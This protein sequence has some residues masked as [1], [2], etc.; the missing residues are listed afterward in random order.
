MHCNQGVKHRANPDVPWVRADCEIA[1]GRRMRR[2]IHSPPTRMAEIGVQS[3]TAGVKSDPRKKPRKF[4]AVAEFL[5]DKP[6]AV[7]ADIE[8]C[9]ISTAK[10][11]LRGGEISAELLLAVNHELLKPQD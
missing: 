4:K 8:H 9:S 3:C 1:W 7:I 6:A 5:W 2:V 11:I 10:R